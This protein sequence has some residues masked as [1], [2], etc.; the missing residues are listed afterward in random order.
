M[1]ALQQ[2]VAA[3][4]GIRPE[5]L[6]ALFSHT[7]AAGLML[8]DR[9]DL[10]GGEAI[11][12][13][14]QQLNETVAELAGRALQTLTDATITYGVGRCDL[15]A[16]RDFWDDRTDQWVCGFHPDGPAD[17]TLVARVTNPAGQMLAT[18]VNYACHPTTLAWEN[19]L[20]SPDYPG[21][22]RQVVEGETKVPCVFVQGASG[23]LGP[24]EGYVGDVAVAERNGRQL[25]FAALSA[26]TALPPPGTSYEY[27]GPVV[28]GATLGV[29][30]H[31]PLDGAARA[32]AAVWGV[33]DERLPI[34]YRSDLPKP[35]EVAAER[36]SWLAEEESARR[37]HDTERTRECRAQ[38][39]RRTRML[40][41]L[42]L[43]PDGPTYPYQ[44]Q[45]WRMGDAIW[46]A[47]QGEPYSALQTSLRERFP[48]MPVVVCS[49]ANGWGPSY[50]P[51]A[52]RYGSGIY[53]E[54]I[55]VLA[56]D[57]LAKVISE[58]AR[59]ITELSA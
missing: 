36:A 4:T 57:S 59:R 44:L 2:A 50:L 14:L 6:L 34:A 45:V 7:H 3:R 48:G 11:P 41:R 25:G 20:I 8:L 43:L 30:K 38:V 40:A 12:P 24:R 32:R 15:A 52:D 1:E 29:W 46:V 55:A 53:Q 19:R 16:H 5:L 21:T 39:E 35:A 49:I 33:R 9:A 51:P 56:P 23:D 47:A 26:L 58:A 13:Y 27:A 42:R 54:S 17:D 28:S 18:L 22:L 31:R 10:P 37:R